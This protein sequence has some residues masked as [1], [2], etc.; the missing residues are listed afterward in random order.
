MP[1]PRSA[2]SQCPTEGRPAG[3]EFEMEKTST[4]YPMCYAN[5]LAGRATGVSTSTSPGQAAQPGFQMQNIC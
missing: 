3:Q 1:T 4:P 2:R 5:L